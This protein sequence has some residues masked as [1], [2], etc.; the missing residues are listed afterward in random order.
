MFNFRIENFRIQK[1][2]ALL[3]DDAFDNGD[4]PPSGNGS[5]NYSL[6]G[7]MQESG[8]DGILDEALSATSESPNGVEKHAISATLLTNIDAANSNLGLKSGHDIDVIGNFDLILPTDIDDFY[9]IRLS[10]RNGAGAPG[11]DNVQLSVRLD[12]DGN[13]YVEFRQLD[14]ISGTNTVLDRHI[15]DPGTSGQIL[16]HLSHDAAN[17]GVVRASYSFITGGIESAPIQMAATGLIFQN[18]NWTRAQF[19]AAANVEPL[20]ADYQFALD[21]FSVRRNGS[22]LFQD[23]FDDGIPPQAA[24]TGGQPAYF[25]HGEAFEAGGKLILDSDFSEASVSPTGRPW[26]DNTLTLLTNVNPSNLTAGLR[27]THDIDVESN[28]ALL[29]PEAT[30]TVYGIRLTDR[31]ALQGLE[32]D[33]VVQLVL[34]RYLDGNVYVEFR[35]LDWVN[36]TST[37]ISTQ[38]LA[39]GSADHIILRLS[40][41]NA[42][43]GVV[44]ASYSLVTAG[45]EGATVTL[46][47]A[48]HIFS[49]ENWTRA[50]IFTG[51]YDGPVFGDSNANVLFGAG[52]NDF[53]NA[54]D[55]DDTI[56]PGRGNDVINGGAGTDQV[57][58]SGPRSQSAILLNTDGSIS[59][60]GDA[61]GEDNLISIERIRFDDGSVIF[62][63]AGTD[64]GLIYRL[65]QAAF[66]RTPDEGGLRYWASAADL[67]SINQLQLAHEFRSAPEFI[68]KYGSNVSNRDYT[69]NMYKNVLGR[70]PDQGGIDYWTNVVDIGWVSRDQLLIEFAQSPENISLTAPNTTAGY[71]VV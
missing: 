25:I 23:L 68:A 26:R 1:N 43:R 32:G 51:A 11:D 55:G 54:E 50:Q 10:D 38:L 70:E 30:D 2:G 60:A 36:H 27:D 13:V 4:P 29:L 19:V 47:G 5:L 56:H 44:K 17:Q 28:F 15:L 39:P 35:Q 20:T 71:W 52:G 59:I 9:G 12:R 53:L 69:Y 16:L 61:I 40:H 18:E 65:Y 57:I 46:D 7:T 45:V 66:A 49:N 37:I 62:D 8:G 67:Y 42:D 6:F 14:W 64:P 48:G 31:S 22:V 24:S 21:S 63:L 3:F 58:Y 41:D 33:D 34:R